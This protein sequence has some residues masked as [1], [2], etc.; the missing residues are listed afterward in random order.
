MFKKTLISIYTLD[1]VFRSNKEKIKYF[2]KVFLAGLLLYILITLL[3]IPLK[4]YLEEHLSYLNIPFVNPPDSLYNLIWAAGFQAIII[5]PIFEEVLFRNLLTINK[6]LLFLFSF[7]ICLMYIWVAPF[8]IIGYFLLRKYNEYE[9][10]HKSILIVST[11]FAIVHIRFP[12]INFANNTDFVLYLFSIP[13]LILPQFVGG[14]HFGLIKTNLNIKWSILAHSLY[15]L[16]IFG[17]GTLMW[18]IFK[19]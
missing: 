15:N 16:C 4:I 19:N 5:G 1:Q 18:L 6:N 11:I 14:Y 13:L 3:Q 9:I 10:S 8:V 7:L 2:I 12:S 17:F